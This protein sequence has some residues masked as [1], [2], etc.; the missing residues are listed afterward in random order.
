MTLESLAESSKKLVGEYWQAP[1]AFSATKFEG[2]A[3]YHYARQ[4]I[5]IEKEKVQ[6]QIYQLNIKNLQAQEVCF[7]ASVST[8][9][10][11][12]VLFEEMA[13]ACG[14][15]G[16]LTELT[17]TQ[18]GGVS[19]DQ[20]M[21]WEVAQNEA[22]VLED[23]QKYLLTPEE[24]FPMPKL[25]ISNEELYKKLLNGS[26]IA[27]PIEDENDYV[28]RWVYL[29]NANVPLGLYKKEDVLLVPQFLF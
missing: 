24:L 19:L 14:S 28:Y 2:K 6:R 23:L 26:A 4:G 11:I 18:I 9:T 29:G 22:V 15:V 17:R 13:E 1:H 21:P 3:L 5:V 25:I 12:R 10:Y 27:C 20:A 7:E 16:H 8:G